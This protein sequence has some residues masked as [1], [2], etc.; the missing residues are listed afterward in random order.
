MLELYKQLNCTF[1]DAEKEECV[2]VI[3]RI[4]ELA[5]QTRL[6]GLLSLDESNKTEPNFFL[7]TGIGMA[8]DSYPAETIS[9][10][11]QTLILADAHK[12][13]ELLSRL[14]IA[15]GVIE[16]VNGNNPKAIAQILAA[17]LGEEYLKRGAQYYRDFKA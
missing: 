11:L 7:Q 17:M 5:Q 13:Y 1:T 8:V 6:N 16:I 2:P 3:A 9:E 15:R 14:L 12:G 4:V 10:F